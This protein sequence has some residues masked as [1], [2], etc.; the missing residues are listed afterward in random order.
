[1]VGVLRPECAK[2]NINKQI[3]TL[4]KNKI[5]KKLLTNR[6]KTLTNICSILV[7]SRCN[8]RSPY[9]RVQKAAKDRRL[10]WRNPRPPLMKPSEYTLYADRGK[11]EITNMYGEWV[12]VVRMCRNCGAK[13]IGY[14]NGKGI[15]KV[16][17][18]RCGAHL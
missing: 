9:D 6:P 4:W 12:P 2:M 11:G 17:C 10:R 8:R 1:M 18:G 7:Y 13:T 5:S 3:R 14:G 16:T 15:V